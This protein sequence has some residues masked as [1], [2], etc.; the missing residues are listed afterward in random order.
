MP[1]EFDYIWLICA[2]ALFLGCV[3]QAA[4]GFGMAIVAAPILVVMQPQWVPYI[5][6]VTALVVSASNAWQQRNAI[7]WRTMTAPFIS[8]IPGTVLG[9]WLLIVM[10]VAT[11][12]ITVATMVLLT[13]VVS[14]WLK[15]FPA[16]ARNLGIAGFV[17]GV[18]GTTTSIGGP[19]MA[20]VMQHGDARTIR[21]NLSIFFVYSC[22]ISLVGYQ[23]TGLMTTTTWL[24]SLTMVPFAL[25]GFWTGKHLQRFVDNSFRPILLTLCSLSASFALVNALLKSTA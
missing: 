16:N 17:S 23:V 5:L 12:Q 18:A 7:Q 24:I 14:L 22:V 6:T 19:P 9:T 3:V 1:L 10:S 20:L 4:I 15:P 21:A 13:V 11:L 25:L 8:R 2:L